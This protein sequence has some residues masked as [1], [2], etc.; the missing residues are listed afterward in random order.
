MWFDQSTLCRR[1]SRAAGKI[2]RGVRSGAHRKTLSLL[3]GT[4]GSNPALSSGKSST[5]RKTWSATCSRRGQWTL[6]T[7]FVVWWCA[8]SKV[9]TAEGVFR[10]GETP[11]GTEIGRF[12]APHGLAVDR[13]GDIYV[14]EVSWTA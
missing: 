13:H 8:G 3:R 2:S 12:L 14:G 7:A 6:A 9:E 5:N 1:A 11:A 4:E 10:I